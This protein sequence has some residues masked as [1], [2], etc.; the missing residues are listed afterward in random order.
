VLPLASIAQALTNTG[1]QERAF[2][3]L[4]LASIAQALTKAGDPRLKMMNSIFGH[5]TPRSRWLLYL[6]LIFINITTGKGTT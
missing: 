3:V 6:G 1:D 5:E 4:P 2:P